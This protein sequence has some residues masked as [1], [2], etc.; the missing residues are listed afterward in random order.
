MA[1]AAEVGSRVPDGCAGL[2]IPAA[3]RVRAQVGPQPQG[4][5]LARLAPA[6]P[7]TC[8]R[9]RRFCLFSAST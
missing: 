1:P 7:L 6:P 8:A 4:A 9:F 3:R 5:H 2:P